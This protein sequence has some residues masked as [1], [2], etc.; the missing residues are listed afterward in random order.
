MATVT[1]TESAPLAQL[2]GQDREIVEGLLAVHDE[3]RTA[4]V[5]GGP[6]RFKSKKNPKGDDQAWFDVAADEVVLRVLE[7]H[8]GVG[9]VLSEERVKPKKFGNG[10]ARLRFVIDP[11]DGSKNFAR[12]IGMSAVAVAVMRADAQLSPQSVTHALVGPLEADGTPMY[13]I[14]GGGAYRVKADGEHERMRTTKCAELEEAYLSLELGKGAMT[15]WEQA[16]YDGAATRRIFGASTRAIAMIAEKAIDLHID[17][18]GRLTPEN[19]LAPTLIVTESGGYA[20]TDEGKP[21]GPAKSLTDRCSV[22]VAASKQLALRAVEI[23]RERRA[24]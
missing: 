1:S 13:A 21:I 17:I 15:A 5:E 10:E 7:E 24:N 6:G 12:G 9:E 23:V 16:I 14:R 11:V 22:I 2:G 19:F 4:L 20:C 18:R 8:F 3:V